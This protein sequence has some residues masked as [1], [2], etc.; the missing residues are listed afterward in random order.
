MM[1]FSLSLSLSVSL[2]LSS[3]TYVRA[4]HHDIVAG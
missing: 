2:S 3:E 4:K 1:I